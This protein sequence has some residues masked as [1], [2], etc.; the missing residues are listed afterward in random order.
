MPD[1]NSRAPRRGE[2]SLDSPE[3]IAARLEELETI[4]FGETG[5]LFPSASPGALGARG[6]LRQAGAA[7][8]PWACGQ[9]MPT[10][11][12]ETPDGQK[13]E[14]EGADMQGA[15]AAVQRLNRQVLN[16]RGR[17]QWK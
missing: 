13:F 10:F 15:V 9:L 3:A 5:L 14:V 7:G 8:V 1:K 6:R 4:L 12:I 17:R 11:H 2:A 16:P